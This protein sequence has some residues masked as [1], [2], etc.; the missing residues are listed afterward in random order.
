M[1]SS[2]HE[3]STPVADNVYVNRYIRKTK[4]FAYAKND[5]ISG[6]TKPTDITLAGFR[7][8]LEA[9][10]VSRHTEDL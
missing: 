4:P 2:S 8:E 10:H 1:Q 9:S 7:S 3:L 6:V 5:G